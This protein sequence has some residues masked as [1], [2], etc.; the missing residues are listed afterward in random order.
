LPELEKIFA[1][2]KIPA[3]TF[4]KISE[5]FSNYQRRVFKL[6]AKGFQISSEEF[7]KNQR[8]VFKFPAK[9]F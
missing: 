2:L 7:L 8:R 9:G 1:S 5:E 6:S 3:K 4:Q